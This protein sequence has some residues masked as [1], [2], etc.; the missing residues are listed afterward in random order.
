M[1]AVKPMPDS[2][3]GAAARHGAFAGQGDAAQRQEAWQREMERAQMSAWFKPS[4]AGGQGNVATSADREGVAATRAGMREAA[5]ASR[6]TAIPAASVASSSLDMRRSLPASGSRAGS[7]SF[8]GST[9]QLP[10]TASHSPVQLRPAIADPS[11]DARLPTDLQPRMGAGVRVPPSVDDSGAESAS[12]HES[13]GAE[14]SASSPMEE[15]P[16]LRLHE[17]SLPE[18]QAVWIAM[19][20]DDEAL[21]AMLPRIVADLQRAMTLERGQRLYQVVCNGRLVWHDGA[22]AAASIS[23]S[24]DSSSSSGIDC[25]PT[26][27]DTFQSKG[28]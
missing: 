5:G 13:Q 21:T 23:S 10:Q 3:A 9:V 7:A 14:E 24:T 15:Q 6:A 8:A 17:E 26:V 27:F 16:P 25:R 12:V 20:A 11:Q 28:A 19:R 2:A 1:S 4:P 22:D 18:G